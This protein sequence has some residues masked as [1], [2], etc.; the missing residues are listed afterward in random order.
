MDT[1]FSNL[2]ATDP[3][4]GLI[5]THRIPLSSFTFENIINTSHEEFILDLSQQ[6]TTETINKDQSIYISNNYHTYELERCL[7]SSRLNSLNFLWSKYL[8]SI[9]KQSFDHYLVSIESDFDIDMKREYCYDIQRDL[10]WLTQIQLISHSLL[11]LHYVRLPDDDTSN[12]FW[13]YIYE[14]RCHSIG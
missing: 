10:Y 4:L 2:V 11:L 7:N 9:D 12:D 3:N 13:A 5:V 14:Q 6:P 1:K 8:S